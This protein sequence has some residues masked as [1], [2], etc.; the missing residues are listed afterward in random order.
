MSDG[1]CSCEKVKEIVREEIERDREAFKKAVHDI[2]D[3]LFDERV[4]KLKTDKK[5]GKRAPSP[6]NVFI[7]TCMKGGGKTM[8]ACTVEW[9]KKKAG[10]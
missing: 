5:R 10:S 3:D 4:S 7:G 1:C 9:K 8:K 2:V 6:Y